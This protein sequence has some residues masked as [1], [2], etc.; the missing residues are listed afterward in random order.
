MTRA[1]PVCVS[2][3]VEGFL[4]RDAVPVHQNLVLRDPAAAGAARCGDLAM[5]VCA[6]CG[7]VFNAAF[8]PSLLAYGEDY[9]NTQDCSPAF[10]SHLDAL[11]DRIVSHCG[12]RG[13]RIVEVGC[14]K[15]GFLRRLVEADPGNTGVGFDPSHQGPQSELGGRLRF[16]R[17]FYDAACADVP[18]DAVVCRHVIEHV[19]DP[20]ALL[21]SIRSALDKS[22]GAKVFFE[23]PCVDWILRGGVI[24]DFFY[25]HCSLFT[26]SSLTTAFEVAGFEVEA[27]RHIFEGQYLWL[28]A[29][30]SSA[31]RPAPDPGETPALAREFTKSEPLALA[32]WREQALTA[33]K[34]GKIAIWGAGAKGAT[35]AN[36]VDPK[37]EIVD[38]LIDVNPG[39]QGAFLAGTGH[40]ILSPENAAA[41]GVRSAVL[42]NPNYRSEIEARLK[43]N[44]T[45]LR[46]I[47]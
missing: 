3:K 47:G 44:R 9:D 11:A 31:R 7:F 35:F 34:D 46:L 36:L 5:T 10:A 1:C 33:R 4:R 12:V 28:E 18:A 23:T 24:W 17:R 32:R 42:M 21:R 40:P 43:R 27:R 37:R 16:E 22:P 13:A 14:G 8:E 45:P 39:K 38:C 15:G 19:A 30:P 2:T 41:R 20:V 26:L 29:R 6:A 25:E